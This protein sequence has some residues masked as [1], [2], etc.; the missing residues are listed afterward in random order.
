VNFKFLRF[1]SLSIEKNFIRGVL[2]QFIRNKGTEQETMVEK[3]VQSKQGKWHV[4]ICGKTNTFA[5]SKRTF[6]ACGSSSNSSYI[7]SSSSIDCEGF[8]NTDGARGWLSAA[9][10]WWL[11]F[12]WQLMRVGPSITYVLAIDWL[13]KQ[14]STGR[15]PTLHSTFAWNPTNTCSFERTDWEWVSKASVGLFGKNRPH[16]MSRVCT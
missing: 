16:M 14:N 9:C 1:T 11:C 6:L 10:D 15:W 2:D 12:Y 4:V 7:A 3:I 13:S 8:S 5:E